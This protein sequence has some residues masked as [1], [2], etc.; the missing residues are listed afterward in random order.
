MILRCGQDACHR[1]HG[2]LRS[3]RGIR[4]R[5]FYY[6]WDQLQQAFRTSRRCNTPHGVATD[7][8]D[9]PLAASASAS[10]NACGLATESGQVP[11][12][13]CLAP[14]LRTARQA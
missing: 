2:W 6:P 1:Y 13:V 3:M 5:K 14:T 12:A 7:L 10:H 4:L 11:L 9:G 8:G